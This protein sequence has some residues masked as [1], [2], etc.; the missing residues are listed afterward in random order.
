M[1]DYR[2]IKSLDELNFGVY[3]WREEEGD[4]YENKVEIF[5]CNGKIWP[6][7]EGYGL[8]MAPLEDGYVH[9]EW[10]FKDRPVMTEKMRASYH[11]IYGHRSKE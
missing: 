5:V 8:I 9:G 6:R 2:K 3:F 10:K 11:K 7:F 4:H 1:S